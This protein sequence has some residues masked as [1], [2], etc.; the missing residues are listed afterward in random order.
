VVAIVPANM[1]TDMSELL[2]I[3]DGAQIVYAM[4]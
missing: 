3:R 1:L 4:C 2:R